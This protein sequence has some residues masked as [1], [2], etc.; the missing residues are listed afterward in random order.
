MLR[1][2]AT[3][4]RRVIYRITDSMAWFG[5]AETKRWV[6]DSRVFARVVGDGGQASIGEIPKNEALVLM[7]DLGI[8]RDARDG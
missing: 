1:Y 5:N 4:N 8:A 7:A 3:D 2:F 6:E